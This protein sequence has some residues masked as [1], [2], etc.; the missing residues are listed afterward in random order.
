[1]GSNCFGVLDKCGN[2]EP[3]SVLRAVLCRA[4]LC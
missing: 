1:M 3:G 2:L 4:V